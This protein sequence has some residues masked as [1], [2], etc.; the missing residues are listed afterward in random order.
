MLH[1]IKKLNE[2]CIVH[3]D[4]HPKNFIDNNHHLKLGNFVIAK[5]MEIFDPNLKKKNVNRYCSPQVL[6]R[7]NH[8][9][10]ADLWS[11]A[12]IFHQMTIGDL[13]FD[14]ETNE[15]ISKDV[16]VNLDKKLLHIQKQPQLT[17]K[18]KNFLFEILKYDERERISIDDLF[19]HPFIKQMKV[20]L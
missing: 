10:K 8:T 16:R 12:I 5:K 6:D 15:Q 4:I 19:F 11:I 7:V 1:A 9:Y 2:F 17:Q 3:R 18:A 20:L 13:P 14:G